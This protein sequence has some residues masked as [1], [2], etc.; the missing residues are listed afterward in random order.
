L[1]TGDQSKIAR[2]AAKMRFTDISG[3]TVYRLITP[4]P[5]PDRA[6]AHHSRHTTQ[7]EIR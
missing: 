1:D 3:S 5:R 6:P 7:R 4:P 2:I